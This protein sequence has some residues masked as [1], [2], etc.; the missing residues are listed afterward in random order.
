MGLNSDERTDTLVLYV[1]FSSL[2]T[3][4]DLSSHN[5]CRRSVIKTY[6]TYLLFVV[7]S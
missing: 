5:V 6:F 4:F 1:F 2:V 7:L 3:I